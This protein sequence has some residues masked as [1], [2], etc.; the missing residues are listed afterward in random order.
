MFLRFTT[1]KWFTIEC[2]L[3]DQSPDKKSWRLCSFAT[4]CPRIS[5]T[6]ESKNWKI[7]RKFRLTARRWRQTWLSRGGVS[8][9]FR[10][11]RIEFFCLSMYFETC[12]SV[13]E[14]LIENQSKTKDYL[15]SK[16]EPWM[17]LGFSWTRTWN[18]YCRFL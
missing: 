18:S 7:L 14:T 17:F 16:S 9:L 6:R 4:N 1:V 8:T 15:S 2:Y 3:T 13:F 12:I 5:L 10:S 11:K